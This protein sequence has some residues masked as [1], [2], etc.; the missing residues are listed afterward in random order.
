MRAAWQPSVA[1]RPHPGRTGRWYGATVVDGPRGRPAPD[2]TKAVGG[3]GDPPAR[4][5]LG[6]LAHGRACGVTTRHRRRGRR[7][8]RTSPS[9]RQARPRRHRDGRGELSARADIEVDIECFERAVRDALASP[10]AGTARWDAALVWCS[11]EALD[12]FDHWRPADGRRAQLDELRS[13]GDRGEMGSSPRGGLSQ[14][15]DPRSRSVRRRRAVARAPLGAV[16]HGLSTRGR[17]RRGPAGLRAGPTHA[18]GRARRVARARA[19]RRVRVAA[20]RGV[21]LERGAALGAI[22]ILRAR[23]AR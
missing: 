2:G 22:A 15:L 16:A 19:R 21:G 7:S 3:T 11:D 4:G 12:D 23:V 8:R 10:A 14:R 9:A 1:R 13:V 6:R 20:P 5:G 18:G 17:A